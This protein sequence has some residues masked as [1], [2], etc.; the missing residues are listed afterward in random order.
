MA[1]IRAVKG[2]IGMQILQEK[3]YSVSLDA[4]DIRK[5]M[6]IIATGI[7]NSPAKGFDIKTA[8]PV[9]EQLQEFL[10]VHGREEYESA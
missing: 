1:D 8:T 7:K 10:R 5:L 6:P 3:K 4:D 2:E 9:I